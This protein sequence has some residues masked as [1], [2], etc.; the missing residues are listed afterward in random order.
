MAFEGLNKL[1]ISEL[2]RMQ[3]RV[4]NPNAR[5]K[6]VHKNFHRDF[7]VIG[8]TENFRFVIFVRRNTKDPNNFSVGLR[9]RA[10]G[11]A[12]VIL[13][14]YNGPSHPHPPLGRCCHIHTATEKAIEEGRSK[15]EYYAEATSR[16]STVEGALAC[17]LEDCNVSG[18]TAM[19]DEPD[20]FSGSLH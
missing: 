10:P 1:R 5:E 7:S 14:R 15:A 3:K 4:T 11:G 18:L 17:L 12:E 20:M 13:K 8:E 6:P 2:L 9:W 16:F 19:N